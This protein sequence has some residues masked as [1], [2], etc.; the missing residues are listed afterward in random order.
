MNAHYKL[1]RNKS[2]WL[3]ILKCSGWV[4]RVR[5]TRYES[6]AKTT[7]VQET[8]MRGVGCIR[9]VI[10]SLA[11]YFACLLLVRLLAC[12]IVCVHTYMQRA[13]SQSV[14]AY[15]QL[16]DLLLAWQGHQRRHCSWTYRRYITNKGID[17]PAVY[18]HSH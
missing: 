10:R 8:A 18:F 13:R 14:A 3:Y 2:S 12:C 16:L 6:Q 11:I 4:E 9:T 15:T 17:Q 1:F 7:G 5:T